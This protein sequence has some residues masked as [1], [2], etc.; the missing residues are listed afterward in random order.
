MNS[1]VTRLRTSRSPA[2]TLMG[3]H[4]A[5]QQIE[6]SYAQES[7]NLMVAA[8]RQAESVH[9]F[10]QTRFTHCQEIY[11]AKML[12]GLP[13]HVLP[14]DGLLYYCW[15]CMHQDALAKW[16]AADQGIAKLNRILS[17]ES[18]IARPPTGFRKWHKNCMACLH[19]IAVNGIPATY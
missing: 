16:L 11:E 9:H 17:P 1:Q 10:L 7:L 8:R 3:V 14:E 15:M 5:L 19:T 2:M 18:P 12:Q 6:I 4:E 13:T